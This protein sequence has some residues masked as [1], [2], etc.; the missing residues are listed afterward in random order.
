VFVSI[1]T[2]VYATTSM[3]DTGR[4]T[5]LFNTQRQ[6]SYAV[7]TALAATVLAAGSAGLDDTASAAER[8][9][10]HRAAFL[11]V[12]L[13]MVPGMVTSWWLRDEDVAATR[14]ATPGPPGE[15]VR[16]S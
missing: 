5:S 16:S 13:V 12:G 3:A 15:P 10:A 1:Q 4:A 6:V 9:P 11:A 2:G 14:V 7:G 8:L